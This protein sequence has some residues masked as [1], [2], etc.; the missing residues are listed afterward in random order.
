MGKTNILSLFA[1]F[2]ISTNAFA[3]DQA[4]HIGIGFSQQMGAV[5]LP[6]ITAHYYP[7]SRFAISAALGIDT[8]KDQSRFGTLL[9]VR[10]IV[11]TE[12]Q[13][14]F[15]MGASAGF[16][17]HEELNATTSAVENKS[18]TEINAIIGGEFYFSGLD[19]LAFMFET[20]I[21]VITGDGGSRFRTI[22]NS[23]FMAGIVFYF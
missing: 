15:Y 11:L 8:K 4:N 16:S 3:A 19:S 18:N 6:M 13:M 14:N 21:G 10:R 17:S 22:A 12:S 9:K 23:P 20:G 1:I 7:N 5:D 2:L